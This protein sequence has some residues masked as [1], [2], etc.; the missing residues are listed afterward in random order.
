MPDA[1]L[2]THQMDEKS[3]I[4]CASSSNCGNRDILVWVHQKRRDPPADTRS[5]SW[6]MCT[7]LDV[8]MKIGMIIATI[9]FLLQNTEVS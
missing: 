1:V 5:N 4:V 7:I 6:G 2:Q 8:V 3:V 9:T